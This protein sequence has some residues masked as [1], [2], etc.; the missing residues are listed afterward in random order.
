M[1]YTDYNYNN[2]IRTRCSVWLQ[3]EKS[4]SCHDMKVLKK[5]CA[6][7]THYSCTSRKTCPFLPLFSARI[8][9]LKLFL[10]SRKKQQTNNYF[11][12]I[13]H[14]YGALINLCHVITNPYNSKI[15][16]EMFYNIISTV[17]CVLSSQTFP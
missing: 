5:R 9:I 16:L 6:C 11:N 17:S 3:R 1:T 4:V 7:N 10:F 15:K 12:K 8:A 14:I 2:S 13:C